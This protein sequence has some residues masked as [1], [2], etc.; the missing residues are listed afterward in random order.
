MV[1]WNLG[2]LRI[3]KPNKDKNYELYANHWLML[4]YTFRK[5][6]DQKSESPSIYTNELSEVDVLRIVNQNRQNVGPHANV[7]DGALIWYNIKVIIKTIKIFWKGVIYWCRRHLRTH[8]IIWRY[9][10]RYLIHKLEYLP[11]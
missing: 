2:N 1:N 3:F 8:S 7:V 4:Y 6:T 11:K 10:S 9:N 5:V